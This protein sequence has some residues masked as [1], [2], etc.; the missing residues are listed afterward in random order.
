MRPA[1]TAMLSSLALIACADTTAT[2]EPQTNDSITATEITDGL[3]HPW[4]LAFVSD[5]E[6]LITERRGTLRRVVDGELQ[7]TNV[8]G[9]PDVVAS[10]QGGLFDV[11]PHPNFAENQRLY[12]SYAQPCGDEGGTTAVGYGTYE[13]G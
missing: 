10:G 2:L 8:D 13:A 3:H 11:L 7:D 5:N 1:I 9:V 4:S 6:W 12:L